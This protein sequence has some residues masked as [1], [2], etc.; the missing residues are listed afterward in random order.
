MTLWFFLINL[1]HQHQIKRNDVKSDQKVQPA[2]CHF[3]WRDT[4]EE[5]KLDL[6]GK[7]WRIVKEVFFFIDCL[8][9]YQVGLVQYKD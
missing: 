3:E 1:V 7:L 5:G 2:V 9:E 6:L 4:V 8:C